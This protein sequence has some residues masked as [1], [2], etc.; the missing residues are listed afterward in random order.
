MTAVRDSTMKSLH[1]GRSL[2]DALGDNLMPTSLRDHPEAVL[3]FLLMRDNAIQRLYAQRSG[4]WKTDGDGIAVL[5]DAD[6]GATLD[7]LGNVEHVA[8]TLNDRGDYAM[9]LRLTTAGLAAHHGSE[10]LAAQRKRSLEGL[11]AQN[12]FNP[13]KL[14]IYSELS[15]EELH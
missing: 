4:Y 11:R 5:S 1:D 3:P 8:S 15:G 10:A 9:A 2:S 6:W 12:Q 7:L 13:F 14:I